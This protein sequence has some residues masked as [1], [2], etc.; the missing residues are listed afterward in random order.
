MMEGALPGAVPLGY[1]V[2]RVSETS[3]PILGEVSGEGPLMGGLEVETTPPRLAFQTC[4]K[5]L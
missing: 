2:L 1:R 5:P 3:L 4:G